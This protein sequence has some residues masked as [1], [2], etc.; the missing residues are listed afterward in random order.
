M[1]S[2]A[3]MPRPVKSAPAA[4]TEMKPITNGQA[5]VIKVKSIDKSS[6]EGLDLVGRASGNDS[7]IQ[8]RSASPERKPARYCITCSLLNNVNVYKI[9]K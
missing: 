2:G 7:G 8:S 6:N 9:S 4:I 1:G 3:S 5:S